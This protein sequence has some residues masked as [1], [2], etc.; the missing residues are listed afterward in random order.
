M[1]NT[2]EINV[3]C[4]FHFACGDCNT[5]TSQRGLFGNISLKYFTY[6]NF[7]VFYHYWSFYLYFSSYLL[8]A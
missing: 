4:S 8:I 7:F 6:P 5:V 1:F 3:N 2:L